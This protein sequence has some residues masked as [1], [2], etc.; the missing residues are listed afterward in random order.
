ME[1]INKNKEY[2]YLKEWVDLYNSGKSITQI[3]KEYGVAMTTVKR[4]I[5]PY[6]EMRPKS[7][8]MKYA[9]EWLDLY[10]KGYKKSEIADRYGVNRTAVGKILS[11][12]GVKTNGSKKYLHL[13]DDMKKMY[14]SGMSLAQVSKEL[15]VSPQLIAN[16]LEH[17]DIDRRHYTE[18]CRTFSIKED[19][20]SNIDSSRKAFLLGVMWSIGNIIYDGGIYRGFRI[21]TSNPEFV[22]FIISE[23]Y[24]DKKEVKYR[25]SNGA[26]IEE[27][28]CDRMLLDLIDLGFSNSINKKIPKLNE[29]RLQ[30]ALLD[31]VL[32]TK[33]SVYSKEER[34]YIK[35]SET[36]IANVLKNHLI[37]TL[38]INVDNIKEY[39]Y[40]YN[41]EK[42]AYRIKGK[43]DV[44]KITSYYE[45]LK[46]AYIKKD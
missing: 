22:D 11:K 18:A 40:L 41:N 36:N 9:E 8:Y 15:N 17:N 45:N 46:N 4:R 37:N 2:K 19:Y 31:G 3:A 25:S 26:Y 13:L 27:I 5:K 32:F 33:I 12:V 7:P 1:K 20:L 6:I 39:P 42:N 28:Y 35:S 38:G 24:Y 44:F 10:N 14:E 34:V 21:T 16:Y 23:I 30:D 43:D 29:K